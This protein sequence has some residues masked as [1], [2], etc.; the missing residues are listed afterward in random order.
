M[1][2]SDHAGERASAALQAEAARRM[3]GFTWEQIVSGEA[4]RQQHGDHLRPVS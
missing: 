3:L 2:G 1:L 4:Y